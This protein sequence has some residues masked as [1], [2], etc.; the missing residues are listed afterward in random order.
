M[1]HSEPNASHTH[2]EENAITTNSAGKLTRQQK[3]QF[4]LVRAAEHAFG[5]LVAMLM[6]ALLVHILR[7]NPD[8][9][10]IILVAVAILLVSFVLFFIHVRP[11]LQT[12]VQSVK[13]VAARRVLGDMALKPFF[14]VTIGDTLFYVD[15]AQFRAVE[16][17]VNYEVFFLP[18]PARVGGGIWLSARKV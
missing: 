3:Q 2:P 15:E 5:A 10:T 16:D 12:N 11:A 4:F 8:L 1:T 7:L 17:D 9:T 6:F 14:C 13:G 18:R